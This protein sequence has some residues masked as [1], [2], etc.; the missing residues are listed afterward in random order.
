MPKQSA[1]GF[2]GVC[3]AGL[4]GWRA[5]VSGI[6][7]IDIIVGALKS[8]CRFTMV[9]KGIILA[10][11]TL[12]KRLRRHMMMQPEHATV[13]VLVNTEK[14][15][16]IADQIL[17]FASR[18]SNQTQLRG[19]GYDPTPESQ[20]TITNDHKAVQTQPQQDLN[21]D[22]IDHIQSFEEPPNTTIPS[23]ARCFSLERATSKRSSKGSKLCN[24]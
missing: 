7:A 18:S 11:T 15:V 2:R 13:L 5:Q 19:S 3:A 8:C 17:H 9:S 6:L 20:S 16:A 24:C 14:M 12:P 23:Y 21:S 22:Y 10:S 4:A 1:S